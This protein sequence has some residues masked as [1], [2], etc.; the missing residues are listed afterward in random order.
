MPDGSKSDVKTPAGYFS[1]NF[2]NI[3]TTS[4]PTKGHRLNPE[5][6]LLFYNY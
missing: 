3:I 6:Y 1:I 4:M 2:G 5:K